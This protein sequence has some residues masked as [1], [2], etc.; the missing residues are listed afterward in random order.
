MKLKGENRP[1]L[2]ARDSYRATGGSFGSAFVGALRFPPLLSLL[3]RTVC[4]V[5]AGT[6]VSIIW[7]RFSKPSRRYGEQRGLHF[8]RRRLCQLRLSMAFFAALAELR[9]VPRLNG[10]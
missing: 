7:T 5:Y 2:L 1:P 6:A 8:I 3:S 10:A 9:D 4:T